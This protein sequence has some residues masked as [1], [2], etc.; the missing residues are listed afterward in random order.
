MERYNAC[1]ATTRS[2]R[3][4]RTNIHRDENLGVG[5]SIAHIGCEHVTLVRCYRRGVGRDFLLVHEQLTLNLLVVIALGQPPSAVEREL[6][7][8][9]RHLHLDSVQKPRRS[10]ARAVVPDADLLQLAQVCGFNTED[11]GAAALKLVAMR[12]G[13]AQLDF[14]RVATVVTKKNDMHVRVCARVVNVSGK[15]RDLVHN[16]LGVA[17]RA[18]QCALY[19]TVV[20]VLRQP[21]ATRELH[22]RRIIAL[23]LGRDAVQIPVVW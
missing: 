5:S 18:V 3:A 8:G 2:Q 16:A 22:R 19:R 6:A 9:R 20:L 13:V 21:S 15:D 12:Q 7:C 14:A 1:A 11:V 17:R 4:G 23:D 10:E